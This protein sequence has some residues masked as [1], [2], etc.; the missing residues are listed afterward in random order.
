[1]SR[2]VV[3]DTDILVDVGR[4]VDEASSFLAG[5]EKESQLALS[6]ITQMELIVG[7]RNKIEL[8]RV[9][10]FLRRFRVI[11]VTETVTDKAV[12]LLRQFR[13]SHGLLIAD[14]LI[15]ATAV[16]WGLPLVSKNQRDYRFIDELELMPYPIS[17]QN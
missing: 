13:L 12:E 8:Q 16:Q 2:T 1:M 5:L 6:A 10:S 7:C 4:G 14:A 11:P 17:R 9:D 15:A 3:I